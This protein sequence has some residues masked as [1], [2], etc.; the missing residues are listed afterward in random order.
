MVLIEIIYKSGPSEAFGPAWFDGR[1]VDLVMLCLIRD[2][3]SGGT[4]D[5]WQEVVVLGMRW[6][7]IVDH[8]C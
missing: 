7:G 6:W 2:S 5:A 3:G 8:G 4:I 1:L